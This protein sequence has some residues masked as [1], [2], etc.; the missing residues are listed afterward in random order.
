MGFDRRIA[1]GFLRICGTHNAFEIMA[2]E[3]WVC[4]I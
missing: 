2:W 1:G 4:W 3:E